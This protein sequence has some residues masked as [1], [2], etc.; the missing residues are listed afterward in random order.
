[1]DKGKEVP[2]QEALDGRGLPVGELSLPRLGSTT[3]GVAAG[4]GP[5]TAD[6]PIGGHVEGRLSTTLA[7]AAEVGPHEGGSSIGRSSDSAGA[8][9][10]A[11][12]VARREKS[13][14]Q[15]RN[16]REKQRSKIEGME[17]GAQELRQQI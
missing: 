10:L 1:M 17:R 14:R 8:E 2:G 15:Q 3:W 16:Y 11:A 12:E 7:E 13:R 5:D 6:P 4:V 9:E